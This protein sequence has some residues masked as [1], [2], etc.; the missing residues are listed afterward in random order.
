MEESVV[1]DNGDPQNIPPGVHGTTTVLDPTNDVEATQQPIAIDR[2]AV[3]V[4]VYNEDRTVAELLRRL[5]AQP[6]VSQII[7]VDD[8][9]TD[10]T[11]EELEPWRGRAG[12]TADSSEDSQSIIVLQHGKNRGKGRAIRTGL[13]QVTCS[14]VIIQDADLEYDPADISK[15]W[16]VMQSDQAKA[17]YGSR[18]LETPD[19]QRGRFVLQSGVRFLNLLVRLIYGVRLTDEA[20]CYKM[21]RTSDLRQMRLQCERFEF[22]P[23]VT[24]K[25]GILRLRIIEVP[26][27]YLP[28]SHAVG[29]KLRFR[30]AI[31]AVFTLLRVRLLSKKS[32]FVNGSTQGVWLAS[33]QEMNGGLGKL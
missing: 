22:C 18:Y 26:V 13:E 2:L 14:H 5:E 16:Q 19:L 3:I 10:R 28:R 27:S 15:L 12:F 31:P 29:K 1:S 11:Y 17:V 21:F 30:D 6:C 20:T 33:R 8:G 4:P 24:A 25:A 9:S 32:V 7:I 23:E